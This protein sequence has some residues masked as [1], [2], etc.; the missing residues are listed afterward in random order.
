MLSAE[1]GLSFRIFNFKLLSCSLISWKG[2][3]CVYCIYF[4]TIKSVPTFF[5][6]SMLSKGSD[7]FSSAILY[8][9]IS[10][11]F[12]L[13]SASFLSVFSVL[14]AFRVP[15]MFSFPKW[16]GLA[17]QCSQAMASTSMCRHVPHCTAEGIQDPCED[18][19]FLLSV[20]DLFIPGIRV[21]IPPR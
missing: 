10:K 20:D 16:T 3:Y 12:L 6:M 14:S 17:T 19:E 7:P 18:F 2:M 5:L 1:S 4:S 11:L 21:V 9:W 15:R 8:G 13:N